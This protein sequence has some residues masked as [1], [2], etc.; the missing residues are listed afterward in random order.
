VAKAVISWRNRDEAWT[1]VADSMR[2]VIAELRA[3][4]SQGHIPRR[5]MLI[6]QSLVSRRAFTLAVAGTVVIAAVGNGAF[7]LTHPISTTARLSRTVAPRVTYR[8]HSGVVR[9]VAWSP[10]RQR[11]ASASWDKTVQA[12]NASNGNH[13][14]TYRHADWIFGVAWSPD[15]QRIASASRDGTVQTW[16]ANDGSDV[17]TYRGHSSLVH[18]VAWSPDGQQVA[19]SS[20]DKTVQGW[21]VA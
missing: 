5:A 4:G 18:R 11:I 17:L 16:N 3:T 20:Y 7:V 2:K 21:D 13:I 10:D 6:Q 8:G 12:W 9:F 19:S 14:I 1:D 15:G